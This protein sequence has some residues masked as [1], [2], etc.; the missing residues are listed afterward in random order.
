MH[1]VIVICG[2]SGTGK[3]T[4]G[5]AVAGRLGCPFIDADDHLPPA[6]LAKMTAEE[7]PTDADRI[8]WYSD[9]GDMARDAL[10]EHG[11]CVLGCSAQT[12]RYRRAI[13]AEESRFRWVQLKGSYQTVYRR[14]QGRAGHFYPAT[15]LQHQFDM[16]EDEPGALTLDIREAPELLV[17]RVARWWEENNA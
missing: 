13:D 3:S 16:W 11:L 1:P 6:L 8:P 17:E 4:L 7:A 9:L 14:V 2:I 12:R 5:A 10:D 15:L